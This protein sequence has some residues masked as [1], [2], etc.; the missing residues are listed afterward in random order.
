MRN[1]VYSISLFSW[2]A[3]LNS[4]LKKFLINQHY[5]VKSFNKMGDEVRALNAIQAIHV[6]NEVLPRSQYEVMGMKWE[7]EARQIHTEFFDPWYF[8]N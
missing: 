4:L 6:V 5:A 7:R 8:R 1:P 3:I 2:R